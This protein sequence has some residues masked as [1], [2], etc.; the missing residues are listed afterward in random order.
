MRALETIF[1]EMGFDPKRI[2]LPEADVLYALART[3]TVVSRT[4]AKVYQRF[5]LSIASFNLLMLLKHGKEPDAFTQQVLGKRLV[6]SPSDMTGLLDR[7]ERKGLVRRAPGKDRRSHLL[8]ITPKGAKLLDDL[9]PHHVEVMT[10]LSRPITRADAAL[11]AKTLVR[12]R[13]AAGV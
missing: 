11:L 12:V 7:L 6:V 4:L 3:T 1:E 9:W 10:R 8:Q 2:R 5:G 13:E